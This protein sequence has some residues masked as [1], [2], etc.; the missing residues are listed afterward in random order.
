[1]KPLEIPPVPEP[2]EVPGDR[3]FDAINRWTEDV[4]ARGE[5]G[6]QTAQREAALAD[7]LAEALESLESLFD[8]MEKGFDYPAEVRFAAR[9]AAKAAIQSHKE[10]R[11]G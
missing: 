4:V 2:K 9:D 6:W 5:L 3:G 8:K 11:N 10:A 7:E 1:M